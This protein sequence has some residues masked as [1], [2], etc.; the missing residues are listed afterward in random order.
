MQRQFG[1]DELERVLVT[2]PGADGL[3]ADVHVVSGGGV[4][5]GGGSSG[6]LAG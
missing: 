3:L 4:W 5:G 2:S 1:A 6:L